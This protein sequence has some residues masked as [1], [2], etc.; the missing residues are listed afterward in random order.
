MVVGCRHPQPGAAE[1]EVRL[2]N[3]LIGT[4]W[5]GDRWLTEPFSFVTFSANGRFT[6]CSTNGPIGAMP[7]GY[8]RISHTNAIT[9]TVE[10]GTMPPD[11]LMVFRVDRITDH[12]MVFSNS[13]E[14]RRIRFS[15]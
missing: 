8:W 3:H 5:S 15:R 4:W 1:S 14:A 10:P 7:S 9:F 13:V 6:R 2:A 11:S 12:E